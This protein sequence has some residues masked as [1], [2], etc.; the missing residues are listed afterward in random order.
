MGNIAACQ[1]VKVGKSKEKSVYEKS[2]SEFL[3]SDRPMIQ[4]TE[5]EKENVTNDEVTPSH[6]MDK[7]TDRCVVE[8]GINLLNHIN[9]KDIRLVNNLNTYFSQLFP[10]IN[11]DNN[12]IEEGNNSLLNKSGNAKWFNKISDK[13]NTFLRLDNDIVLREK[14]TRYNFGNSFSY[15]NKDIFA[16]SGTSAI[17]ISVGNAVDITKAGHHDEVSHHNAIDPFLITK[18]KSKLSVLTSEREALATKVG[19]ASNKK[20]LKSSSDLNLIEEIDYFA[21]MLPIPAKHPKIKRKSIKKKHLKEFTEKL[22]KKILSS[23]TRGPSSMK[24]SSMIKIQYQ[25]G[26]PKVLNKSI[27][28]KK[29]GVAE[30]GD[31]FNIE[32]KDLL[33]GQKKAKTKSKPRV[34]PFSHLYD[35]NYI[36]NYYND[37]IFN[38]NQFLEEIENLIHIN[39]TT[40]D[41][42]RKYKELKKNKSQSTYVSPTRKQ[43]YTPYAQFLPHKTI[44]SDEVYKNYFNSDLTPY[45]FNSEAKD[46]RELIQSLPPQ[47][48]PVPERIELSKLR[49]KNFDLEKTLNISKRKNNFQRKGPSKFVLNRLENLNDDEDDPHDFEENELNLKGL[50]H[51]LRKKPFL[52]QKMERTSNSFKDF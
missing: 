21:K 15:S 35:K 41:T 1:S 10:N 6:M 7:L 52:K 12:Q 42:F 40:V 32:L 39:E 45:S 50:K 14:L 19:S 44:G 49:S 3:K 29:G 25:N 48:E 43:R 11:E 26:K 34:N 17:D 47:R 9:N 28:K 5:P 27:Y 24:S 8:L 18:R 30:G 4:V 13:F 22:R 23:S 46:E 36:Q 2:I 31:K 33:H 37:D 51:L 16:F 20:K 38:T